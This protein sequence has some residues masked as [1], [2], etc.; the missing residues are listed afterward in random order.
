M[1]K[2]VIAVGVM[3]L[4]LMLAIKDG[5]VLHD[6]GLTGYCNTVW[7]SSDGAQ[8]QQCHRGVLEGWP[9]LSKSGCT[10]AGV[11]RS[12]QLWSCPAGLVASPV[13]R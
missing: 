11:A 1:I 12:V 8:I 7:T 3:I 10:G 13:G 6:V 2:P 9:D 4:A 5:R